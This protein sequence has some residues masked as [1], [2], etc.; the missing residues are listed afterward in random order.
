MPQDKRQSPPSEPHAPASPPTEDVTP[1]LPEGFLDLLRS[2]PDGMLLLDLEGRVVWA[3]ATA[4]T[5]FGVTEAEGLLGRDASALFAPEDQGAARETLGLVAA[6]GERTW[7]EFLVRRSDG[8]RSI[9]SA[10]LG[11]YMDSK[12]NPAGYTAV[13]RDRTARHRTETALLESREMLRQVLDTIP[14]RVFWKDTQH[15]FIG[16][17]RHFARDAGLENPDDIVGKTDFDYSFREQAADY[18]ADDREV[19]ESGEPK[20]AYEEPQ[21]TPEGARIWLRTSKI[22]LRDHQ[23]EI[24]GVLGC[25]EDITAARAAA[26]ELARRNEALQRANQELEQLHRAKDEFLAMV[27]HELRT[28][29]VTGIGY[30]ELLLEG[31]F[32]S[33]PDPAKER[34]RIALRNLLRL[35]SL[36]QNLLSYQ[37]VIKPGSRAVIGLN[38]VSVVQ[39]ISDCVSEFSVRHR[40]AVHRL[41]VATPESLPPVEAEEE[42]LRVVIANLLDNAVHHAGAGATIRVEASERA[43]GVEICVSDDGE[44]ISPDLVERVFEPFVKSRDSY[45]GSGLGLAIVRGILHAHG[46]EVVLQTTPGK[47]TSLRFM[48]GRSKEGR[49]PPIHIAKALT[50][51]GGVPAMACI[52]IVEDD[53]DTR[54]FLRIALNRRG[55]G[56]V[57]AGSVEEALSLINFDTVD[58]CLVDM[59]LP[60]QDGTALVRTLKSRPALASLPMLMLTARA[61]ESARAEAEQAGCDGYLVKPVSLEALI[62]AIRKRLARPAPPP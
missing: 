3:N 15:R 39:V 21:T 5:V 22:P 9:L 25:Y 59:T 43:D 18:Q 62:H 19:I 51:V 17:N 28:P 33:L 30:L 1:A 23:G 8:V 46:A 36:I 29:L 47:G 16:C 31:R 44:G 6:D 54:E 34:M 58:L 13:V 32:G 53:E 20:L 7:M 35:S 41:R 37:S 2:A 61:E 56:V 24:I 10:Q 55:Y 12:G 40:Q 45:Q 48:L 50:P 42:L 38:P 14:V 49:A 26:E 52:A 4:H 11:M 27:S 60:G 57:E